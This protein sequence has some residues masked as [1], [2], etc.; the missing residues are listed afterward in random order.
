MEHR[1]APSYRKEKD[2]ISAKSP[3]ERVVLLPMYLTVR[4]FDVLEGPTRIT[5][6][7][8]EATV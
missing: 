1:H 5:R 7:A 6:G 4:D 3:R 2:V 8:V